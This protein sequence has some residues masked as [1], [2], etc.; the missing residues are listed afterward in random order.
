MNLVGFGVKMLNFKFARRFSDVQWKLFK[1]VML[2]SVLRVLR[3]LR[4]VLLCC[5]NLW[6]QVTV[7]G[8]ADASCHRTRTSETSFV[9]NPW[10]QL[11]TSSHILAHN[12]D[13][14][15][16]VQIYIRCL[17]RHIRV[18]SCSNV[19]SIVI[20][21]DYMSVCCKL[22]ETCA[23]FYACTCLSIFMYTSIIWLLQCLQVFGLFYGDVSEC[24][25]APRPRGTMIYLLNALHAW[26]AVPENWVTW[27]PQ[28]QPITEPHKFPLQTCSPQPPGSPTLKQHIQNTII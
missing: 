6:D 28:G 1:A 21:S 18:A 13:I 15:K 9:V 10:Q 17:F 26:D 11:G 22:A 8:A 14:C 5:G 23:G 25:T 19:L 4:V 12:A 3:V 20:S 7:A 27:G 2:H 24:L 16:I